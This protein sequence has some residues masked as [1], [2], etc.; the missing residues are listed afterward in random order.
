MSPEPLIFVADRGDAGRRLDQVLVRRVTDVSRLSRTM[1]QR[2]IEEGAVEIDAKVITRPSVTVLEGVSI[3]VA[4]PDGAPRRA[5]PAAEPTAL[6]IVHEDEHVLLIN[7]PA[8][9]VAH[10]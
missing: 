8:G 7:K 10:P 6:D 9:V 5:R 3:R 4:V 2:W 1:A